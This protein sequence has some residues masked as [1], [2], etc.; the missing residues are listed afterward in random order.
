[1]NCSW[2]WGGAIGYVVVQSWMVV[3]GD[4]DDDGDMELITDLVRIR[5]II[6]PFPC[7]LLNA[8]SMR[9]ERVE[10]KVSSVEWR[11]HS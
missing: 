9:E 11:L 8:V 3:V 7:V 6:I 10:V 5:I 4:D 2:G 1:M